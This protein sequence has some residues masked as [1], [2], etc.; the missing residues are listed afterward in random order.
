MTHDL[1][2][3]TQIIGKEGGNILTLIERGRTVKDKIAGR[4]FK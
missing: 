4:I 3:E 1:S 2:V